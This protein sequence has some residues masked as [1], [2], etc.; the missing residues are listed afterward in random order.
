[1]APLPFILLLPAL[2][3]TILLDALVVKL[4][5]VYTRYRNQENNIDEYVFPVLFNNIKYSLWKNQ[6]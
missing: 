1:M 5:L 3:V 2:L 6:V 4:L